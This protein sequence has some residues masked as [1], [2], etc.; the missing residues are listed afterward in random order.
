MRFFWRGSSTKI[1][2]LTELGALVAVCQD[3]QQPQG[4]LRVMEVV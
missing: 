2:L 3:P 4:S 1:S